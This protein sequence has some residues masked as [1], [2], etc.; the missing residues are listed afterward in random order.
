[1]ISLII[2]STVV[3]NLSSLLLSKF[4][5][6][7]SMTMGHV[8]GTIMGILGFVLSELI[9]KERGVMKGFKYN[10]NLDILQD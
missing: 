3:D 6:N 5:L 9:V 4:I 8:Y 7:R 1:M 10:L 2:L